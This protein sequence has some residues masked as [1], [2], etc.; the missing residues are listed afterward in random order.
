MGKIAIG[1]GPK[2]RV[3]TNQ[4]PPK[5]GDAVLDPVL[6]WVE[7]AISLSK[8]PSYPGHS[9]LTNNFFAVLLPERPRKDSTQPL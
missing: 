7:M 1:I 6:G 3:C 5:R 2:I 4:Q 9:F 8:G